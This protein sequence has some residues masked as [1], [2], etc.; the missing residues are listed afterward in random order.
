MKIKKLLLVSFPIIAFVLEL[1]P[2]GVV[3]N[4]ANHEGK[5][6]CRTY[7]Y[8]SLTPFGYANF[9][10]LITAIMTCA[11]FLLLIIFCIK[12]NVCTAIK[13]KNILYVA[14]V[15]SLGPLVYGIE[16]FSLVA[17]F[18]TLSLVAELFLLKFTIKA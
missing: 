5:P 15:I 17:G 2:Y 3:L 9:A 14:I 1:L 13:A 12:G 8:F 18:I 4:F 7:S 6:W 16:Y 10:P 11:I